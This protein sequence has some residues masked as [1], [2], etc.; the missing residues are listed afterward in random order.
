MKGLK[1][2]YLDTDVLL[3]LKKVKNSSALINSYLRH[4]LEL[5]NINTINEA[6]AKSEELKEMAAVFDAKI[7][8]M[9]V[10]EKEDNKKILVLD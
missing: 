7:E 1:T 10:I 4:Y 5:P 6:K 3:E 2:F 8:Q 9:E